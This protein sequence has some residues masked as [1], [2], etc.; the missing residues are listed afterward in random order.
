LLGLS[1]LG[2]ALS[3]CE[4]QP[5]SQPSVQVNQTGVTPEQV[6]AALPKLEQ[7]AQDTLHKTGVPGMAIA[8]VYQDEALYLKGFGVRKA[9]ENQ[10]V[11]ADTVF[12]LASVSKPIAS[13]IVA[14][15]VG[16][17]VVSWDDPISKHDPDFRMDSAYVTS[18][19]TLRDMFSH[20]SGLPD[21]A[22]DLLEDLGFDRTTILSRLR[23]LPTGEH[24]RTTYAY[25]NFGLTAA[26]VA[27]AKAA[28]TT[29][30]DLAAQRLYQ[31][32]GMNQT[33]SRFA[34]YEAASNRALL[35]VQVNGQRVA[36]YS[37]D[38]DAQSPAGGVSSTVRDLAQWMRLQLAN[39]TYEGKSVMAA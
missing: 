33:S 6:K 12:Q 31:R 15:V 8:V 39:G 34:D 7:L 32:L 25:T 36:K 19:V 30:E 9:G 11:D 29:W 1:A 37:R 13:T 23:Y 20:R 22:G 38:A 26:A 10:P 17:G 21:H 35:H 2:T 24:F 18:E 28:G 27:A 14:A 5:S 3:A 4:Q 16:D